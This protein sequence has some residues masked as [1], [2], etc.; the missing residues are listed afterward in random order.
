N[1]Q[2]LDYFG[3][4]LEEIKSWRTSDE[5]HPDD[6]P[7]VV[8]TFDNRM[9]SPAGHVVRWHHLLIDIEDRRQTEERLRRSEAFLLEAQRLSHA[10]NWGHTL[11]TGRVTTSPE[12]VRVFDVQPGEDTSDP[13]FWF[14]RMHPE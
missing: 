14:G 9:Q 6:L 7:Q 3:R 4:T 8:A 1:P 13:A 12:L 2:L 5:V 10:G 11:S